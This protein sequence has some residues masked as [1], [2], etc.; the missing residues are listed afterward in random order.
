MVV[1]CDPNKIFF[2]IFRPYFIEGY[3]DSSSKGTRVE[4]FSLRFLFSKPLFDFF[5]AFL[6]VSVLLEEFTSLGFWVFDLGS[7][8]LRFFI[9]VP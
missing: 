3:I 7:S 8:I 1:T 9:V 6:E 5:Q 2:G 4:V